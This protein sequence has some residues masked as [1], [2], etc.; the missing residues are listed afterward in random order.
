MVESSGDLIP[1]ALDGRLPVLPEER[2]YN[3]FSAL[4]WTTA[5][6]STA[7]YAYLIG[8]ALQSYGSTSLSIIGYLIG[9][10][11]GVVLVVLAVG[12]VSWRYGIDTIDASKSALGPRGSVVLLLSVLSTCLGW[13]YVLIAMTARGI[14]ELQ[15]VASQSS[16]A[17]ERTVV[18]AG[19]AIIVV[20]WILARRGPSAM[21]R[22]ARICAIVQIIVALLILAMLANKYGF[23]VLKAVPPTDHMTRREPR[24]SIAFGVEFGF[25][26]ALSLLPF[27]GG[28]T[29]LVRSKRHLVGPTVLGAGVIGA[30][31]IATVAALAAATFG[32]TNPISWI[33]KLSDR[34]LAL[35]IIAFLLIANV[36]TMV[37]QIYVASVAMQQIRA[38][39]R[40]QIKWTTALA[41][42][43]AVVLTFRSA[44]LLEHV[45]TWLAYNGVMFVGL[46]GVL[47]TDFFGVRRQSIH[48]AHLFAGSRQS[49]YWYAGG[50]NW[51]AMAALLEAAAAYLMLF[52]PVTLRVQPLFRYMGAGIPAVLICAV[53]YYAAMTALHRS[54]RSGAGPLRNVPSEPVAALK[55]GL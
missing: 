7:S 32:D 46:A 34:R 33:I 19:L 45:M 28:L 40:L 52:D 1:A 39:A 41:L 38:L 42:L 25:D 5:V 26:N 55:V 48:V 18:V 49:L 16:V 11:I 54:R 53:S 20:V 24:A 37:V 50:V 22:L 9:L 13:A 31:L 14:G 21:E 4:L 36:G 35:C 6:L 2:V 43:P 51:I 27:L 47:I 44:W 8:S 3:S 30:S 10:I 29:R 23:A 17:D 15:K 12:A